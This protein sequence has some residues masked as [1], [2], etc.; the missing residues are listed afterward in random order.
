MKILCNIFINKISISI[1]FAKSQLTKK[2]KQKECINIS[3]FQ[4]K[5]RHTLFIFTFFNK[6]SFRIIFQSSTFAIV[7]TYS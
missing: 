1:I 2:E 7:S 6:L 3:I 5:K 4:H